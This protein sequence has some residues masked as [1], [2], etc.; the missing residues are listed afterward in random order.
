MRLQT[1]LSALAIAVTLIC[2]CGKPAEDSAALHAKAF[3]KFA[4]G[5]GI[6][7]QPTPPY[8]PPPPSEELP[9]GNNVP[10]MT[11]QGPLPLT[12]YIPNVV[13]PLVPLDPCTTLFRDRLAAAGLHDYNSDQIPDE[14]AAANKAD[15][16]LDRTK[17][18]VEQQCEL[19]MALQALTECLYPSKTAEER[20][21]KRIQECRRVTVIDR[22]EGQSYLGSYSGSDVS[23]LGR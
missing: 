11:P 20:E 1:K 15:G 10:T 23:I 17:L 5:D 21:V 16:L 4:L 9:S 6:A 22:E 8:V 13:P 2:G 3:G 7:P 18:S 14:F 19:D 12:P